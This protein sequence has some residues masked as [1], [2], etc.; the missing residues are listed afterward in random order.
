M[1]LIY[2]SNTLLRCLRTIC[3]SWHLFVRF[4]V[5]EHCE[6]QLSY[7]KRKILWDDSNFHEED[8]SLPVKN[9]EVHTLLEEK[10]V[11]GFEEGSKYGGKQDQPTAEPFKKA[12]VCL[13]ALRDSVESLH[14]KN[15]F[16]YNP[17]VLLKR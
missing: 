11:E 7:K 14:K 17:K 8:S 5:N 10:Y 1:L 12:K 3:D 9:D 13:I 4:S 15:L 6:N 2:P 16:P